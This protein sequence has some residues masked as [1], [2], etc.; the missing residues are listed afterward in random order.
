MRFLK[1]MELPVILAA[2]ILAGCQGMVKV[3]TVQDHYNAKPYVRVW[4]DGCVRVKAQIVA[5]QLMAALEVNDD[6][7]GALRKK[8]WDSLVTTKRNDSILSVRIRVEPMGK[9]V[10]TV[11]AQNSDIVYGFGRSNDERKQEITDYNLNLGNR[12]WISVEGKRISPLFCHTEQSFGLD[13]GRDIWSGFAID[14]QSLKAL[15][16]KKVS[17]FFQKPTP[18]TGVAKVSWSSSIFKNVLSGGRS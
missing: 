12:I 2:I 17:L 5:P 9:C 14:K 16:G 13:N 3:R 10:D 4:E 15:S 6:K 11:Y 18:I 8:A 1:H 7:T